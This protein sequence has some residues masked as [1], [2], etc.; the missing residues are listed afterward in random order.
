MRIAAIGDSVNWGQ[1]LAGGSST[2]SFDQE[3]YI[4]RCVDWLKEEGYNP[5]L[6][7][8]DFKP[9]S[10]AII[11]HSS[12]TSQKAW[13]ARNEVDD[14]RIHDLYYGEVPSSYPTILSQL[15]SINNPESVDLIFVNGGPN[16]VGIMSSLSMEEKFKDSLKSIDLVAKERLSFLL[17]ETRTVCKNALV[18]YTGYYAAITPQSN[19]PALIS[20]GSKINPLAPA[21]VYLNWIWGSIE[22]IF[23]SQKNRLKEQGKEFHLR[24]SARFRE[25]IADFNNSLGKDFG[26]VIFSPSGFLDRNAMWA[27]S[28]FVSSPGNDPNE[29]VSAVRER[30]CEIVENKTDEKAGVSCDIAYV[31]HPNEKGAESYTRNLKKRVLSQLKFSLRDHCKDIDQ[32]VNSIGQLNRKYPF[33]KISS[34][35]GLT[36]FR[37]LD[38]ISVEWSLTKYVGPTEG[39]IETIY[40]DFG[41]GF[42]KFSYAYGS[43]GT[44]VYS[45][46]RKIDSI[47]KIH[48]RFPQYGNIQFNIKFLIRINGYPF[49][50]LR[51]SENDFQKTGEFRVWK[52]DLHF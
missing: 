23:Q 39:G 27:E 12:L 49:P 35:K 45:R 15:K 33:F 3:K 4:F 50:Y 47:E 34:L 18:I 43:I 19:I 30:L 20:I 13:I 11:G 37:W 24:M 52:S 1:G 40:F 29:D 42:E 41:W 16:D 25:T 32:T 9:H 14:P 5:T 17:K 46:N 26:N 7:M 28:E 44:R 6:K 8:E 2:Q 36:E 22:L 31:G 38:T 10:G 51:L 48:I 21:L